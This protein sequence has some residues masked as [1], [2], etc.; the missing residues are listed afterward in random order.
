[1]SRALKAAKNSSRHFVAAATASTLCGI[2][3]LPGLVV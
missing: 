1:M 2:S 3:D